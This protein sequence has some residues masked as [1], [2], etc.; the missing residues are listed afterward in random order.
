ME[1]Q[2]STATYPVLVS[3][4]S[5]YVFRTPG[6]WLY[7]FMFLFEALIFLNIGHRGFSSEPENHRSFLDEFQLSEKKS[8]D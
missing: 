4:M 7:L 6:S 5:K 3:R 8:D 1:H 2:K